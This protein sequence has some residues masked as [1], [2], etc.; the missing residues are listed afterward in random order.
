LV[1]DAGSQVIGF[2]WRVDIAE[3][4]KQVGYDKAIPGNLD[5][6]VLFSTP[7]EIRKHTKKILDKTRGKPGLIFNLGHGIL[8]KTPVDNVMALVD[9]VHEYSQK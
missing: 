5:P 1:K 6:V 2:D 9:Y 3:A 4:W 7:S 8:P